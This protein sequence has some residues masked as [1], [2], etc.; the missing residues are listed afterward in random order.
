MYNDCTK[1]LRDLFI[2][3]YLGFEQNVSCYLT[4]SCP[5]RTLNNAVLIK[6]MFY[7]KFIIILL[8]F[9]VRLLPYIQSSNIIS[10]V[11][12]W[13]D[14]FCPI[15]STLSIGMHQK[16]SMQPL[17]SSVLTSSVVYSTI[18]FGIL[19]E[20]QGY[21]HEKQICLCATCVWCLRGTFYLTS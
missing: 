8:F 9:V 21:L 20:L 19:S 6:N 13:L 18:H 10:F 7:P 15:L 12:F 4:R 1:I 16:L 3:M 11:V 5:D 2:I 17:R 14:C